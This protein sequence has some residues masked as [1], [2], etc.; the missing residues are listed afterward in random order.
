M[1]NILNF[2][3]VFYGLHLYGWDRPLFKKYFFH[4]LDKIFPGQETGVVFFEVIQEIIQ[5]KKCS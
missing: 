4:H 1:K 2:N 5:D 3:L